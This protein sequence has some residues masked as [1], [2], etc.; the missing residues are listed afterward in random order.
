M[1]R[2]LAVCLATGLAVTLRVLDGGIAT[3]SA[4]LD[5]TP[6]PIAQPHFAHGTLV[7]GRRQRA[8]ASR[9]R[10]PRAHPTCPLHARNGFR[11]TQRKKA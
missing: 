1:K 2:A 3:P 9:S 5:R 4:L 7:D 10:L 11:R 8:G 6:V